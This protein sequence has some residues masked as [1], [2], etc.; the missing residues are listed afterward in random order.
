M[1]IVVISGKFI[2]SLEDQSVGLIEIWI[3]KIVYEGF[4]VS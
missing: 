3:L 4:N 1:M 2:E